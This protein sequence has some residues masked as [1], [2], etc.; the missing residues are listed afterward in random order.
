MEILYIFV[1]LFAIIRG[2]EQT[3]TSSL[4]IFYPAMYTAALAFLTLQKIR[5]R[6]FCRREFVGT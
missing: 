1:W 4:I 5:D 3:K 2:L 6:I